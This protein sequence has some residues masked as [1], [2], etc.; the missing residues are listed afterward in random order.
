M[1]QS[2]V[3]TAAERIAASFDSQSKKVF[4]GQEISDF[5]EQNR[6]SWKLG[7]SLRVERFIAE[8]ERLNLLR[9]VELACPEYQRSYPRYVWGSPVP[10]YELG[11]SVKRKSYYSN[12]SAMFFHGL[13]ESTP[14]LLFVNAE[15]SEKPRSESPLTQGGIDR[16]FRGAGR[17]SKYLFHFEATQ[18]CLLSGKNTGN[19]GTENKVFQGQPI[20]LTNL[21]R[22]LVD[23]AVRPAYSGGCAQVLEAYRRANGRVS[24]DS[25]LGILAKLD[26]VYPYHQAIGF[27]MQTA[28]YGAAEV[29]KFKSMGQQFDFY[30][31]YA[32]DGP[33]YSPEWRIHYPRDIR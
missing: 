16:A 22:T 29:A 31:D 13:T 7:T 9:K 3:E 11:L 17:R 15:Q 25:I 14:D 6:R 19:L 10:I 30:L 33:S 12:H 4:T 1:R 32:M 20:T 5:F 18:F 21:E 26:Y 24:V 8:L 28:G 27:Y 2:L 23:I